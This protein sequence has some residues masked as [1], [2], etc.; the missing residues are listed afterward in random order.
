MKYLVIL[1]IGLNGCAAVIPSY[2]APEIVHM[3]HITQHGVMG[4]H[5]DERC[6]GIEI[7]QL[8]AHW[9]FGHAMAEISD[10][11]AVDRA[12]GQYSY[13]EIYGPREQFTAKVGYRFAL[14]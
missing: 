12:S 1:A 5:N 11:I 4:T 8:T 2:V 10:G 7:I 14:K 3:S 6:Q 13:G 9:D